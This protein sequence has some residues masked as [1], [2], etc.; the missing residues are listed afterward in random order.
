MNAK[1]SR[2]A[3]GWAA[4]LALL[5]ALFT[6]AATG[7][8]FSAAS[9]K[10]ATVYR[11]PSFVQWPDTVLGS[12]ASEFFI[13]VLGEISFDADLRVYE[14]SWLGERRVRVRRLSRSDLSTGCQVLVMDA[15]QSRAA[16]DAPRRCTCLTVGEFPGFA[17]Q[18][19][20]IELLV[21]DER[22]R[23]TINLTPVKASGLRVGSALLALSTV[24]GKL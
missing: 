7:E 21:R 19:G 6:V 11:I 3:L 2:V 13:C 1:I 5:C 23:I 4:R 16:L 8:K 10:A 17:S 15:K 14:G 20:M 9:V 24:I 12:D 22:I 18:G